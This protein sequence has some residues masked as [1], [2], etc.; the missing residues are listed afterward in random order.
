MRFEKSIMKPAAALVVAGAVVAVTVSV[1]SLAAAQPADRPA[2]GMT[3]KDVREAPDGKYIVGLSAAP[4]ALYR[5]GVA[6]LPGTASSDGLSLDRT[7][8]AVEEYRSFLDDERAAVLEAVPGVKAFYEYDWAY[9]GFAAELTY[10]QA[11]ALART[12]GVAGVFPNEMFAL[13]TTHTPEFLGISEPG[14]LWEQAGGPEEAGEGLVLGIVDGGF[15]PESGSFAPLEEPAPIPDG[16]TGTCDPGDPADLGGGAIGDDE[17]NGTQPAAIECDGDVYNNKVIAARYFSDGFGSPDPDDFLSPRDVGGHGS[18]TGSTSGGNVGVPITVAGAELGKIS[19]M[20]PRARIAA[21]KACWQTPAGGSCASAD[22][23]MA[24]DQAVADG[25][26]AINYSI[27]GSL[28]SANSPDAT[29]FRAAA[30][31]GIFVAVSAGNDGATGASTVAHNYP[32]VTTVAAST[33]DRRFEADAI[34]ADGTSFTGTSISTGAGPAPALFAKNAGLPGADPEEVQRC[35]PGTLDPALVDGTIVVCVRGTNARTQKSQVVAD[36]GGIGMV[37]ANDGLSQNSTNTERHAVPTV[38]LGWADGVAVID[39]VGRDAIDPDATL[40]L[41][42]FTTRIGDE[43]EAPVMA[44]F[45]SRGPA[46]MAYGDILKPDITAPGVDILAS[47]AP[48]APQADEMYGFLSGTSMASPH[49][50]GLAILIK[51]LHPDWS[52][53]AIK[54]AIITGAYQENNQGGPIERNDQPAGPF[55][56]GAGHVEPQAAS[57]TPLVYESS[58][59]EWVRWMCATHQIPASDPQCAGGDPLD[60]SDLNAASIAVNDVAGFREVTRTVTN[61]TDA[62]VHAVVDYE[63]PDGF[64]FSVTPDEITVPPGGTATYTL[65]IAYTDGPLDIWK[66][67][68]IT[69]VTGDALVRSPVVVKAATFAATPELVASEASGSITDPVV[70]GTETTIDVTSTGLDEA[71]VDTEVLTN[72][73]SGPFPDPPPAE[74]PDHIMKAEVEVAEGTEVARFELF[75]DDYVTGTDLDLY[76]YLDGVQ[77]ASSATGAVNEKVTMVAP[78]PGTYEVYVD[79]W[80]FADGSQ[81]ECE[82]FLHS[83]AVG[84]DGVGDFS[85]TPES[86]ETQIGVRQ[87]MVFSWTGLEGPPASELDAPSPEVRRYLGRAVYHDGEDEVAA[88]LLRVDVGRG[89][90]PTTSPPTTDPTTGPPTTGPPTS[91]P[92]PTTTLPGTGGGDA[93]L[94]AGLGLG[95][96]L[97]GGLLVAMAA[98]RLRST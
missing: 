36:A 32:W 85:V 53:M 92:V 73:T 3:L 5:G 39:A 47:L 44:A 27:G 35:M 56:Y 49:I 48:Y 80:A 54:S 76:V 98:R 28:D 7:T 51:S 70:A 93:G 45:S 26:D 40:E 19:G 71:Q 6:D 24:I 97:V 18:H 22:T 33:Q 69:W 31:A 41:T 17:T 66:S 62:E 78:A 86:F 50:A 72:P 61:V 12:P 81:T 30:A 58:D 21:Y 1:T 43:V 8:P 13:E 91:T 15:T 84:G 67:G 46:L 55:D 90:D 89:G 29:A 59:V 10:E 88:T 83:W 4:V 16:F 38:H 25:V 68:A 60:P 14:G 11:K 37:L 82:V 42:A 77:V 74:L 34:L 96:L 63:V 64:S 87:D 79:L 23:T 65:R 94:Y 95:A 57:A 52:P 9:A 2:P 20:A 75:A